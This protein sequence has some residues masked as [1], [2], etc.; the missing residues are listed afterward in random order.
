MNRT[1][2]KDYVGSLH[3]GFKSSEVVV[4]AHY[5]GLSVSEI[6]DLR[7]KSRAAGVTIKVT[8]NR[9]TKLSLKDT[10]FEGLTDMFTGPTLVAYAADPVAPAKVMAEFAKANDKLELLGGGFGEQVM[11]VAE[12]KNLATM[13]SLDELRAK[14]VGLLQAPAQNILGVVQAPA[15]QLARVFSAYGKSGS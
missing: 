15:G 13:P 5:K 14:L 2:K 6:S 12:V 4:V 11:S 1:E 10:N 7:S 9:L 3:E 8:K